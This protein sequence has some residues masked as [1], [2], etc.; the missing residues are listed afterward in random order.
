VDGR[1]AGTWSYQR[2]PGKLGVDV[3]MFTPFSKETR[4]KAKEEAHDLARFLEAPDI[5]IRFG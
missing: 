1:V 4:T 3:K 5:A 2:G